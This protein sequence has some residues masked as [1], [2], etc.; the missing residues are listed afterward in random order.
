MSEVA[1]LRER[2]QRSSQ[3]GLGLT[4]LPSPVD[5]H[6]AFWK[7]SG[8]IGH[9]IPFQLALTSPPTA[10]SSA[11]VFSQLELHFNDDRPPIIITHKAH[12]VSPITITEFVQLGDVGDATQT[13][14]G[15]HSAALSWVDGSTKV[16]SG[17][18]SSAKDLNLTVSCVPSP[19][20][21]EDADLA[22]SLQISKV[23]L[24]AVV[25]D[26]TLSFTLSPQAAEEPTWR[27]DEKSFPLQH[28]SPTVCTCVAF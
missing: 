17:V 9:S 28:A 19:F 10:R 21:Q 3:Q 24:T 11:L 25:G 14:S 26:W 5:C 7:P 1:P 27:L 8:D 2:A 18:V 22:P 20:L 16:F 6:L 23:I 15:D 4:F 13:P 12:D